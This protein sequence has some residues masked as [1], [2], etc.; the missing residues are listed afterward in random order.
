MAGLRE[1]VLKPLQRWRGCANHCG[2]ATQFGLRNVSSK[3][4]PDARSGKEETMTELLSSYIPIA[5]FI[6]IALVIG[7][8]LLIAPFAVAYK[9]PDPEK[10]SAFECGLQRV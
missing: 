9:N 2:V 3:W 10:L 4:V 8:A 5:I 6:G 1:K 7:L